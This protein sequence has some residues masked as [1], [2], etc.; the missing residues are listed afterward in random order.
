VLPPTHLLAKARPSGLT[1]L[2]IAS[3]T[4]ADYEVVSPSS[5]IS[6]HSDIPTGIAAANQG[7][8][9]VCSNRLPIVACVTKSS[10]I[11]IYLASPNADPGT[12]Q[13]SGFHGSPVCI[14]PHDDVVSFLD[15]DPHLG[16]FQSKSCPLS[17]PWYKPINHLFR[18]LPPSPINC[19]SCH[20]S[21][22][23]RI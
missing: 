6:S 8:T 2:L 14:F 12:I 4:G 16:S 20:V 23:P 15:L 1:S 22:P 3:N 9:I 7:R 18:R 13:E 5:H 21:P 19:S 11:H 10:L 17:K